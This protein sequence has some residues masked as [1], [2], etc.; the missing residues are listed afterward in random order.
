MIIAT[1]IMPPLDTG[2]LV[3]RPRLE[4][5]RREVC[6]VRVTL[7]QAPAGYGKTTLLLRWRDSMWRSGLKVSWL[8]LDAQDQDAAAVLHYVVAAISE[9]LPEI[10]HLLAPLMPQSRLSSPDTLVEAL[11]ER[12]TKIPA[13]LYL[14]LDD[15]HLI[16]ASGARALARLIDAA[17]T[18]VHFI[19]SSREVPQLPLARLR[20]KGHL[21]EI[22]LP[23]LLFSI[24]ESMRFM[25]DTAGVPLT[26]AEVSTLCSRTEGW[27]TALRLAGIT[28]RRGVAPQQYIQS[29]TGQRRAIADFFAEDVFAAL[30]TDLRNFLTATSILE[31]LNPE[32]CDAV[33]GQM[34]S[35]AMLAEIEAAGLFLVPLDEVRHWFRYH[36]L[37]VEFL[38]RELAKANPTTAPQLHR[39]AS[40]WY[41]QAGSVVEAL[42]HAVKSAD[43]HWLAALLENHCETLTYTGQIHLVAEYAEQLPTSMREQ[44][45]M[46]LLTIAW[47]RTRNLRFKDAKRLLDLTRQY[48]AAGSHDP[49]TPTANIDRCQLML[50]H[51]EMTLAA[52]EDDMPRVEEQC[53][54]LIR[55]FGHETSFISCTLYGQ[56]IAARMGQFDLQD[57]DKLEADARAVLQGA[58]HRFAAVSLESIIGSA[59]FAAGRP[60]AALRALDNGL[61]EGIRVGGVGSGFAAIPAL[62]LSE[63]LYEMN[64]LGRATELVETYLPV[65]REFGFV[66]QLISGYVIHPRLLAATGNAD[67]AAAALEASLDQFAGMELERIHLNL[68]AEQLRLAIKQGALD[69][70]SS[71]ARAMALP[72]CVSDVLPHSKSTTRDEV[73]ANAWV[74]FAM[75]QGKIRDALSAARRW[76]A[77]CAKRSATRAHIRWQLLIAQ[78]L[79]AEGTLHAAQRALREVVILGAQGRF[80]RS[81]IDEG[82]LVH[83]MMVDAYGHGPIADSRESRFADDVIQAFGPIG[84]KGTLDEPE[85]AV[86]ATSIMRQLSPREIEIVSLVG[87][88]LRN[89]EIGCR[90][91]LTEGSVKWYMQQIFDKVGLRRRSQVVDCARQAGLVP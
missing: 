54:S 85:R 4:D 3:E 22:G 38:R 52:A 15:M 31:R 16:S 78:L 44:C 73:R 51:R 34:N 62:P 66:D 39:R 56:L 36:T 55:Q 40:E 11:A 86:A 25:R 32:L 76:R 64:E 65:A 87:A 69:H 49:N 13:A 33:T 57:L 88:G 43:H 23:D 7:V 79:V 20:A 21:F 10:R 30:S 24:D 70:A 53:V 28:M 81:F 5:Q 61:A 91:G 84:R 89:G 12:L 68:R 60:E 47:L 63:V 29:L 42:A 71:I 80:I 48:L 50:L 90:L 8:T 9:S 19:V 18:N 2:D 6:R 35:R 37:F 74:R 46:V 59:H 14:F 17:P 72:S 26:E 77:F 45:P 27:V 67:G 83:S 41:N 75:C 1:K 58:G 82:A